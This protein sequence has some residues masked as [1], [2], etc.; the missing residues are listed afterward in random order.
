MNNNLQGL[1][2]YWRLYM[3]TFILGLGGTLQYGLQVSIM[4]SPAQHIQEF[5]NQTWLDRYEV[6]VGESTNTLIW[7]LMVSILSVGGLIGTIHSRVLPVKYGRKTSMQINNVVAILAAVLMILCQMFKS[8]E[9]ILIARIMYGYNIG[10]GINLH[11][12]YLSE[13]SPKRLR[14]FLTLTSSIFLS[15]GKLL[16]QILGI[17]DVMGTADLWPYLLGFSGLPA[18]LQFVLLLWFPETPRYLFIDRG[19]EEGCK[20]VLGWLW[21][22]EDA[23]LKLELEDM[24]KER[25]SQSE[26]AKTVLDTLTSRSVRWQ[27]LAMLIPSSGLQFCGINAIYFYAFHIF[28]ESGVPA[29]KMQYLSL[30]IGATEVI[31]VSLCGFTIERMGRKKLLGYGYLL[32]AILM[33]IL[34]VMLTIKDMAPWLPYFNIGL[35]FTVI[36]VY[37]LG[38]SGASMCLPADLFLQVWRP[39]AF[40]VGGIVN[41]VSLFGIGMVFPYVVEG[42]GQ[43]CFLIF[44]TYCTFTSFFVLYFIPETKGKTSME[45]DEDFKKLN[46]KNTSQKSDD[47]LVT[48]L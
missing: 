25:E 21:Q 14:G 35:L 24:R 33:C 34:I 31:T 18:M 2:Q 5:V 30:G 7:S 22:E 32:M 9:M 15:L 12:M 19:D 20:K 23:G 48:K 16:G 37:G 11:L 44:V 42:M 17:S 29:E 28:H 6:P 10:M 47:F 39:A 36:C 8:F 27:L 45:I 43:Y 46:F 13:I 26:K 38:P 3:L 4:T 40:A 1:T 41:W